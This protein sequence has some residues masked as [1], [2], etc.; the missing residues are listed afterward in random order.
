MKIKSAY[1]KKHQRAMNKAIHKLNKEL[2]NTSFPNI[3]VK[4]FQ[5]DWVS[6]RD[7]SGRGEL[8]VGI[9]CFDKETGKQYSQ[10]GY[11]NEWLRPNELAG[12]VNLFIIYLAYCSL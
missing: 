11:V 10:F 8:R 3:Y 9:T 1:R 6:D 12:F 4:Q 7:K 5:A 2:K